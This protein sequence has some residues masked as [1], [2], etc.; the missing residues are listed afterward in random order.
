ME[1]ENKTQEY[2]DI[3]HPNKMSLHYSERHKHCQI[4]QCT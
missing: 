4:K 1:A 2:S 3:V